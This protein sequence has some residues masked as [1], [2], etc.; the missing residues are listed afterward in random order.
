MFKPFFHPLSTALLCAPI[1]CLAQPTSADATMPVAV[2]TVMTLQQMQDRIARLNLELIAVGAY[3]TVGAD[4]RLGCACGG[5]PTVPNAGGPRGPRSPLDTQ[6]LMRGLE[7]MQLV[8]KNDQAGLATPLYSALAPK[9][10]ATTAL[11]N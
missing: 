4:G 10:G 11:P 3:V 5:S 7:V 6:H 8:S 2:P 1:A 9:A